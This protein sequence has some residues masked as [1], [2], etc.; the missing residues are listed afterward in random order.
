MNHQAILNY[1]SLL[2]LSPDGEEF[3]FILNLSD[4]VIGRDIHNPICLSHRDISRNH[5]KIRIEKGEASVQDLGSTN[6]TKL[7]GVRLPAEAVPL[8]DGDCINI[9]GY[10]IR[11]LAAQ[12]NRALEETHTQL[13]SDDYTQSAQDHTLASTLD[14]KFSTV[15]TKLDSPEAEASLLRVV[16]SETEGAKL[17]VR[18][19]GVTREIGLSRRSMTLGRAK[20]CSIVLNDPKVS[21]RHA[22]IKYHNQQYVLSDLSS[23]NGVFVNGA[24]ITEHPLIQGDIIRIGEC[25][26]VFKQAP[27]RINKQIFP[28]SMR[29]P[30]VV[31]PGFAASELWKGDIKIWPNHTRLVT[32]SEAAIQADWDGLRVGRMVREVSIIPGFAKNDTFGRLVHYLV[33]DLGYR[34]GDDLLEFPYDWR[35]DNRET[36]QLLF[37]TIQNWRAQRKSPT[38]KIVLIAH[39]MGGL[40]ARL[41]LSLYGGA[42]A[43]ER[44]IFIGTPHQG[45][46]RPLAM[47][48]AGAGVLPFGL[49]LHKVRKLVMRF[50]SFYQLLPAF[51]AVHFD[52]GE[53]FMPLASEPDWLAPE[54]RAPLEGAAAFRRL[55]DFS[56]ANLSVPST[57]IFGYNQKTLASMTVTRERSGSLRP[58]AEQQSLAGDGMVTESSAVLTDSEIH[59]VI[60]QH[61]ALYSDADVLRRLRYELIERNFV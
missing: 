55:L 35:K 51:P 10:E 7:N 28:D 46:P 17:L 27:G 22:S 50:P 9:C 13:R 52:T 15:L 40:I 38:E 23:R 14:T 12:A 43:V 47:L 39:S 59:P 29:R 44:C 4:I 21:Y 11:Y 58:I 49:A 34:Q 16:L 37:E 33:D 42:D 54:Y 36:A 45:V 8:R 20:S 18:E 60:Q 24:K 48:L 2:V 61:G 3:Q 1:A 56:E 5:A 30:V 57:C 25:A 31:I 41:Y 53:A 26:L 32:S 6:G 19:K